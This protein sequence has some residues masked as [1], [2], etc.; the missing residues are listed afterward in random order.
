MNTSKTEFANSVF[1]LA[2]MGQFATQ[3]ERYG[4]AWGCDH[5]CPVFRDGG[6]KDSFLENLESIA[7]NNEVDDESF[8]QFVSLYRH[9]MTDEEFINLM[10]IT[11]TKGGSK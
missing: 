1:D 10:R 7:R 6:C 4:M 11:P 2:D 5:D 3:C 8:S 9:R